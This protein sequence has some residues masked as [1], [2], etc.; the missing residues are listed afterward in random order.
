M[1]NV[2]NS[3][4]K[5]LWRVARL[6]FHQMLSET[7]PEMLGRFSQG[8]LSSILTLYFSPLLKRKLF[9]R[10]FHKACGVETLRIFMRLPPSSLPA[11]SL[12]RKL[13]RLWGDTVI[14]DKCK[15]IKWICNKLTF[16]PTKRTLRRR[17]EGK[18]PNPNL[19]SSRLHGAYKS[20]IKYRNTVLPSIIMS[21]FSF[22]FTFM[23]ML[24]SQTNLPSKASILCSIMLTQ[25]S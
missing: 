2:L 21:I 10:D 13:I 14:S 1:L 9:T 5:H 22:F 19:I 15:V 23:L 8:V 18:F 6:L 17:R 11:A 12:K 25:T 4:Y 20:Q 7:P 24:H 16:S 3:N